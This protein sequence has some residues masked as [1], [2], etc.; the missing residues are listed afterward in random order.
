MLATRVSWILSAFTIGI[1]VTRKLGPVRFGI[2]NYALAL[3]GMFSIIATMS[4]DEIAIRQLVKKSI[5]RDRVLGNFFMVRLFLFLIMALTLGITLPLMHISREVRYLCIIVGAGYAGILVQGSGLYFQAEV[6]SKYTALP[7]LFSC[8]VNAIIRL[9]AAYFDWPLAAFAL[10][11]SGNVFLYHVGCL[12]LYWN[13]IASPFRWNWDRGEVWTLFKTAIP[14]SIC[15]VFSL[16]Y[17][18]TDQLMIEH[19]LG[20]AAVGYYSL[21]SRFIEN[22]ALA[23][24]LLC[25]SFFPAIVTASQISSAA[26]HKQLHRLYFM[27]FW[28][29]AAAAALTTLL[30][31]SVILVLFG[32]AYLPT[33]PVLKVFSW[34]LLGTALLYVFSQWAINEKRLQMI[35]SGFIT[36]AILNALLNPLLIHLFG[37]TGAAWSS[38]TAMPLGLTI[39]LLCQSHGREHFKF[40]LYSIFKFPSFRLGEHDV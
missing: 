33:V 38:L 40:M 4:I 22:W 23:A 32:E 37:I 12:G 27:V 14:L 9:S 6:E 3:T 19:F 8:L 34:T 11:E 13:R 31:R 10:A 15:S 36:G 16:V 29:M 21:A 28:C 24:N 26:Y 35:A 18:R 30:S 17:A 39:A 25:I 20:P 5:N 7:Q 1:Y 2:L